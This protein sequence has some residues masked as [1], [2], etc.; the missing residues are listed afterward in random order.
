[1]KIGT[2]FLKRKYGPSSNGILLKALK[3][4]VYP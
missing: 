4:D 2:L 3:Y 1:M